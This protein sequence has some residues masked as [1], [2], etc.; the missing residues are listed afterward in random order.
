MQ[1]LTHDGN[2]RQQKTTSGMYKMWSLFTLNSVTERNLIVT[3]KYIYLL[4][5][6]SLL[7]GLF[8][9][10]VT[11]H[12]SD[13]VFT[14]VLILFIGLTGGLIM[15]KSSKVDESKK[16]KYILGGGTIMFVDLFFISAA[17]GI[18]G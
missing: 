12:Y 9:P 8:Y 16:L 2:K 7:S 4:V 15:Y 18:F 11:G 10:I 6:F 3:S 17:T 1:Y 14:G 13:K 5:F